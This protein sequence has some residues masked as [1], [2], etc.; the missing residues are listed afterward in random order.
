MGYQS[1]REMR[2][3]L[4]LWQQGAGRTLL[5]GTLVR[6]TLPSRPGGA[7]GRLH[8]P[9]GFRWASLSIL[10]RKRPIDQTSSPQ[11][12]AQAPLGNRCSLS[13]C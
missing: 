11:A 7:P 9:G 3:A 8:H 10:A 1:N 12:G 13:G 2:A 4:F 5:A 6:Q